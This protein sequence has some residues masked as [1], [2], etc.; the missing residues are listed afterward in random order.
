MHKYRLF[1]INQSWFLVIVSTVMGAAFGIAYAFIFQQKIFE[2]NILYELSDSDKKN[3]NKIIFLAKKYLNENCNSLIIQLLPLK[4]APGFV[5]LIIYGDDAH[6][7]ND[8]ISK[9]TKRIIDLDEEKKALD[10]DFIKSELNEIES[11]YNAIKNNILEQRGGF[12]N[13]GN[14]K[15]LVEKRFYLMKELDSVSKKAQININSSYDKKNSL[16]YIL[17]K[18]IIGAIIGFLIG[19][20]AYIIRRPIK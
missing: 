3:Q 2:A 20:L 19:L 11:L 15:E 12:S 6:S 10:L 9:F 7:V 18:T 14:L 1:V 4:E 5:N 16:I 17:T 13:F 8:C